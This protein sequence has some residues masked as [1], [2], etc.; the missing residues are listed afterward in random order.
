MLQEKALLKKFKTV[1]EIKQ[2]AVLAE[3][4]TE[5]Y[6][7]LV[8]TSDFNELK[9]IV[10]DLGSAQ[11]RTE[12]SMKELAEAQKQ[13]EQRMEEL[14]QVQ[15]ELAQAQKE[16]R[17]EV[18]GLSRSMSYAL[19]NEAYRMLPELLKTRYGLTVTERLVRTEIGGEE[20][21]FFGKGVYQGESVLIVGETKLRLD[22]RR[23]SRWTE[24]DV[25]NALQQKA[26]TVHTAYPQAK[27]MPLLVTHYARPALLKR[28]EEQGVILVQ[29]FEW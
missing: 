20:I 10:R 1:F 16:T 13:T 21:N 24:Q 19:E 23:Q 17:S 14:A 22:E 11:K 3:T 15:E 8:K 5:A 2:A 6:A 7:D 18:G 12:Q 26:A 28:A 25:L 27:I 4:I 29:S 9:E